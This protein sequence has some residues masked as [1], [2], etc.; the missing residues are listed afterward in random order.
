MRELD[1]RLRFATRTVRAALRAEIEESI[2]KPTEPVVVEGQ[3]RRPDGCVFGNDRPRTWRPDFD[4][5]L[6]P[7]AGTNGEVSVILSRSAFYKHLNRELAKRKDRHMC[8]HDSIL[9]RQPRH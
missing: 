2:K 4:E 1:S 8:D 7:R 6:P 5:E 9:E 3:R